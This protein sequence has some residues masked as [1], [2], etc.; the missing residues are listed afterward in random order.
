MATVESRPETVA[1]RPPEASPGVEPK[2]TRPIVWWAAI[3]AGFLAF[4]AYLIAKWLISGEAHRVSSGPT[5]LPDWMKIALGIQQWGLA[6][7]ALSLIYFKAIR[8]RV[9]TGRF[10]FDGLM[11]LSFGLMWWSDPMYNYFQI[12]FNY[13]AWFVNLGS[14]IGGVP[15][16]M[17]P[18]A[19]KTPQPL[20]W[21]PAVYIC[22]FYAM[23]LIVNV[24]LR[25]LYRR[26]P[27][28][29]IPAAC[30]I[31]FVPMVI[32]G[33]VCESAMMHMGSHSYAGAIRSLTIG[34]G[35]FYEFPVYQAVT[36]SILFT[37]WGAMRFYR[38]DHGRSFVE[39]GAER[40]RAGGAAQGWTRFFAISGAITLIFFLGYHI[41]NMLFSLEGG[42]WPK[43]VQQRSYFTSGLC[44]PRTT[45][46]C[47]GPNI[48]IARGDHSLHVTPNGTL[49]VP[50]GAT[51]PHEVRQLTTP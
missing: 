49:S 26:R 24:I 10:T 42:A 40:L 41:P 21:L 30:G 18:H 13:N 38:D 31:T 46:A 48:P 28:L 44:G 32:V 4:A 17:S 15:G 25:R 16:W 39:R 5:P 50:R 22:W 6:A 45:F 2:R 29:S 47:P 1:Q 51:V 35:K 8:P 20:I 27:Q 43:S 33:A 14:W 7:I 19:D 36:A 12:G 3:G 11:I 23:V 34:A 9:R 37:T